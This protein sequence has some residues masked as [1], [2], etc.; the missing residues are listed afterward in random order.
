M[1]GG[2]LKLVCWGMVELEF[3]VWVGVFRKIWFLFF[4]E[5]R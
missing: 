1:D 5:N 3:V 2:L 4:V